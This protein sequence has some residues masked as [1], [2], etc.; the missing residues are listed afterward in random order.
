MK[1]RERPTTDDVGNVAFL[2]LVDG[3]DELAFQIRVTGQRVLRAVGDRW[4]DDVEGVQ[5]NASPEASSRDGESVPILLDLK[6]R[7]GALLQQ[8]PD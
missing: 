1:P 6:F 8:L 2:P 5:G 4:P 7:L 3:W